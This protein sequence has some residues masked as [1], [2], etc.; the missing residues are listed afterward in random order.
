MKIALAFVCLVGLSLMSKIN[1]P[2]PVSESVSSTVT[3][4]GCGYQSIA[5]SGDACVRTCKGASNLSGSGDGVRRIGGKGCGTGCDG[6]SCQGYLPD[7]TN[8]GTG[9]IE[10]PAVEI[11]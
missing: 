8:S 10:D 7:C 5:S 6:L 9:M 2:E 11:N 3:G 1:Q 4:A